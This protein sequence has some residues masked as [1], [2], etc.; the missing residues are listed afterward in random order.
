MHSNDFHWK[1]LLLLW[2][3][4]RLNLSGS[5]TLGTSLITVSTLII[6]IFQCQKWQFFPRSVSN[7]KIFYNCMTL[8]TR[9]MSHLWYMFTS[10]VLR[11]DMGSV[12]PVVSKHWVYL[13][14]NSLISKENVYDK[15]QTDLVDICWLIFQQMY[16]HLW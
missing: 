1:C 6:K 8:K 10:G 16:L 15:G 5:N 2:T 13:G 12:G 11:S 7:M 14:E 4:Q 9:S 3:W